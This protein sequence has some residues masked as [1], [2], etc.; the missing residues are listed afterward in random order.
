[1]CPGRRG[2]WWGR[3]CLDLEHLGRAE[4]ALEVR[5]CC[6]CCCCWLLD[7]MDIQGRDG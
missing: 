3:L 5:C 1:M 7:A 2:E 6:C 4:Q